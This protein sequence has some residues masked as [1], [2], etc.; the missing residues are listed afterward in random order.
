M[1]QDLSISVNTNQPVFSA[2]IFCRVI[3]HYGDAGVC[4]R[5]A[6]RLAQGLGWQVRLFIDQIDTLHHLVPA[7]QPT[8]PCQTVGKVE[9]L[10]WHLSEHSTC[11][12]VVVEAFACDPPAA[13]IERMCQANPA[14]VWINL[15]YFS[16]E[17]WVSGC[18]RLPSPQPNGL[19][20]YFFFPGF[21]DYT[22]GVVHAP[23][24]QSSMLQAASQPRATLAK[25]GVHPEP[26]A[27]VITLFCY[28][29]PC[30]EEM[31]AD[32]AST[33]T[34]LHFL[35]PAGAVAD[36]LLGAQSLQQQG[37]VTLQRL[38]FCPQPEFDRLLAA[39]DLN[40]V[41]GEDSLVRA[42]LTG[43]PFI[44]NIYAQQDHAHLAKLQAFLH[45]WEAGASEELKTTVRTA[46]GA[47]NNHHWSTGTFASMLQ[48][49][50][51]WSAHAGDVAARIW[52]QEDLGHQLATFVRDQ[53][54]SAAP[55]PGP[56]QPLQVS[57]Q[58][59]VH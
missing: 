54:K 48:L 12:A 27:K 20:K 59:A 16:A 39:C 55:R 40:F 8:V 41:R 24:E 18:H 5:L 57:T 15:E 34:P 56:L 46:H 45:W 11:A 13:Y 35:L 30:I 10:A 26:G 9:V 17:P 51:A 28:S 1:S 43:R 2:D 33:Q 25:F 6:Q 52:L 21:W 53:L 23:H 14:P 44:W 42:V 47:W 38:D 32:A 22:G 7:V 37:C 31:L 29:A 49:L 50:E 58:P 3:D 19:I 4:W 36:R